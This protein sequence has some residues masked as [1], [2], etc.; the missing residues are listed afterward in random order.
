MYLCRH[1]QV[2]IAIRPQIELVQNSL[3]TTTTAAARTA[4]AAR[5]TDATATAAA[6]ESAASAATL[7]TGY[8]HVASA[9]AAAT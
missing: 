2:W 8:S 6:A 5:A 7:S 1:V 3:F 9:V 4:A